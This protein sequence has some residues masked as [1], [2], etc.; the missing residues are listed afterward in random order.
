MPVIRTSWVYSSFGNN[1]VKTMQRLSQER[2][3]ISVVND[4][5]GSPTYAADLCSH[6]YIVTAQNWIPGFIIIL[7][8]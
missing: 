7:M 4:Q 1:F 2:D 3:T 6:N 8:K 5:I